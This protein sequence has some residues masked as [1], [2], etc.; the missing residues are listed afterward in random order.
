MCG[1]EELRQRIDQVA[2][3][4]QHQHEREGLRECARPVAEQP[5]EQPWPRRFGDEISVVLLPLRRE[6]SGRAKI[7]GPI[8]RRLGGDG[9]VCPPS[10]RRW[11]P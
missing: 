2:D 10:F 6:L 5:G 9:A 8:R 1:R 3:G 7:G 11:T 4:T